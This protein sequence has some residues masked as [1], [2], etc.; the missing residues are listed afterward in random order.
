MAV[1]A[2]AAVRAVGAFR[3]LADSALPPPVGGCVG[4]DY[5]NGGHVHDSPHC[6]S[7][8]QNVCRGPAAE[9]NRPDRDVLTRG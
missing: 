9:E 7:R 6:G 3:A 5:C 4:L 8:G 1:R 2:P